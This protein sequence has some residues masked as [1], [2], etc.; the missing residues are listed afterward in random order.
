MLKKFYSEYKD[1][2]LIFSFAFLFMFVL[3]IQ[4]VNGESMQPTLYNKDILIGEKISVYQDNIQRGDIITFNTDLTSALGK[5]KILVKRVIGVKNDKVQIKEG[6]V[7]INNKQL[8]EDYIGNNTTFGD[9]ELIVPKDK[10]F[11]LGDNR[12]N[13]NDSRNPS[14]GLVDVKDVRNRV[15]FKVFSIGNLSDR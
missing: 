7:Y 9:I 13:S 3:N 8:T 14:V 5:K 2:L 15:L 12:E 10:L 4:V 6:L 1:L 11:V